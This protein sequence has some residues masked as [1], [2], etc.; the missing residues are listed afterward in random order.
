MSDQSEFLR[1]LH[2]RQDEQ[3]E[4]FRSNNG[5]QVGPIT[6]AQHTSLSPVLHSYAVKTIYIIT[7]IV[8][9]CA[10]GCPHTHT[11]QPDSF[12]VPSCF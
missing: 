5:T 11:E 8:P 1:G 3:N 4:Q 12:Q 10:W 9:P 2:T 6:G 7:Q